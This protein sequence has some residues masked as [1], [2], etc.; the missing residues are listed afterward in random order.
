MCLYRLSLV[1]WL[2]AREATVSVRIGCLRHFGLLQGSLLSFEDFRS[3]V[4]EVLRSSNVIMRV[5]KFYQVVLV[6]HL[7]RIRERSI[8]HFKL[9]QFESLH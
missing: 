4:I 8:L 7:L 5:W 9:F 3:R 6:R 1:G 2:G